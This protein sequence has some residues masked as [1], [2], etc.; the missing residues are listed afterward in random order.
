MEAIMLQCENRPDLPQSNFEAWTASFR[1]ACGRYTPE[2]VEANDFA[3]W[4]RSVSGF[5]FAAVDIAGNV[6]RI[7]RTHR[8]TRLDGVD[9]YAAVFQIAGQ[10]TVSQNDQLVKLA[11]GDVVLVD[12]ARPVTYVSDSKSTQW[13][14][15][16]LPRKSL[17]SHLGFEPQGGASGRGGPPARRL[18]YEVAQNALKSDKEPFSP[19]NSYLQLA[20]YDL[21]G[22]L[23]APDS[24]SGSRPTD[25]LLNR[26]RGVIRDRFADPDFGPWQV[27]TEAGISLRY[28]QKLFTERGSTCSE[29]IY[30][31]RLDHAAHLLHRRP[32][33]GTRQPLSEV[34]YACGFRDYPHFARKFRHRFGYSPGGPP[35][36]HGRH[37]AI[38]GTEIK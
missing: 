30:S 5:G 20:V 24:W 11:A 7:E 19:A 27:A 12:K 15:L 36:G 26:I 8:D 31:L 16:Q 2:R 25:K 33:L 21:V 10:S 17:I 28:V 4:V 9:Q 29:Y 18:L 38:G 6:N 1:S 13:L 32:L 22:A 23:F 34:A 14:S 37:A 35:G 3:G